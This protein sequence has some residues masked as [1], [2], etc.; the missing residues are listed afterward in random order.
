M[1][2]INHD[3]FLVETASVKQLNNNAIYQN[4]PCK[5]FTATFVAMPLQSSRKLAT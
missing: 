1:K 3:D 2:Y 5:V 4:Q